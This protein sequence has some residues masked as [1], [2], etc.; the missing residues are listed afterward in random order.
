VAAL[1][2]R[3]LVGGGEAWPAVLL[4]PP[5]PERT[6]EEVAQPGVITEVVTAVSESYP[7]VLLDLGDELAPQ[8]SHEQ[9]L[10]N[11]EALTTADAVVLVLGGRA[12]QLRRGLTQ[13]DLLRNELSVAAERLRV[14]VN[15]TGGPGSANPGELTASVNGELASRGLLVDA[16]LPWDERSLRAA[17]RTGLP[18]A[19][20]RRRSAYASAL[21]QLTQTLFVSTAPVVVARKHR[22]RAP[23][24]AG[25]AA[26]VLEEVGLPWRQ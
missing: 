10:I 12:D 11:R 14:V 16:W 6:L 20:S 9:Q 5:D 26:G 3:W 25:K 13:L 23:A 2:P 15:G 1:L 18:L 19:L 4:G 21:E 24:L 7:L 17:T 8:R 22:L